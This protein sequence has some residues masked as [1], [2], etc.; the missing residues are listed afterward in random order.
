MM[1]LRL[2]PENT[3]LNYFFRVPVGIAMAVLG[4]IFLG[5]DAIR[6]YLFKR[7]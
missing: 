4:L 7:F 6:I 1:I 3:I 5:F 2:S